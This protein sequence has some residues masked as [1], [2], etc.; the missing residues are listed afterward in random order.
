MGAGGIAFVPRSHRGVYHEHRRLRVCERFT[1]SARAVD[2]GRMALH[3]P[4][5]ARGRCFFVAYYARE[6]SVAAVKPSRAHGL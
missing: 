1:V 4:A 2:V 5:S 3:G 6:S